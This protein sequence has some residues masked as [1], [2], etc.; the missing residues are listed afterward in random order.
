MA[1]VEGIE[2]SC[3]REN[4]KADGDFVYV[5]RLYWPLLGL[6]LYLEDGSYW[7]VLN[8]EELHLT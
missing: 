2:E 5:C 3:K 6:W 7:K 4:Q 1:G 8:G